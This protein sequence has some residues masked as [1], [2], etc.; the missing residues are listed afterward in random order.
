MINSDIIIKKRNKERI[1]SS[2]LIRNKNN[3]FIYWI[4]IVLKKYKTDK[5]LLKLYVLNFSKTIMSSNL[6]ELKR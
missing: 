1:G 2:K 6:A 5:I 3:I 4:E